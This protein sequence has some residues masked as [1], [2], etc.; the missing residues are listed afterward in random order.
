MEV[1]LTRFTQTRL[2]ARVAAV[3]RHALE[4][5]AIDVRIEPRLAD[6]RRLGPTRGVPG[7]FAG[8]LRACLYHRSHYAPEVVIRQLRL[9][10]RP[11]GC[12]RNIGHDYPSLRLL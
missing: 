12:F 9:L 5:A 3:L 8:A 10:L 11:L 6:K 4:D 2:L 7:V 1:R